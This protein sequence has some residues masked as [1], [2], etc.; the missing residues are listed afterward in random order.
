MGTIEHAFEQVTLKLEEIKSF[1]IHFRNNFRLIAVKFDGYEYNEHLDGVVSEPSNILSMPT[2]RHSKNRIEQHDYRI[3]TS[4]LQYLEENYGTYHYGIVFMPFN[5][6]FAT[7]ND[8]Q[9][10]LES[11]GIMEEFRQVFK[12]SKTKPEDELGPQVLT[13]GHLS[14]GFFVCF[15]PVIASF[16]AFIGELAWSKLLLFR[17]I[18]HETFMKPLKLIATYKFDNPQ[19]E[20]SDSSPTENDEDDTVQEIMVDVFSDHQNGCLV[21]SDTEEKKTPEITENLIALKT[22]TEK[23]TLKL[24]HSDGD[25]DSVDEL[26]K[27]LTLN[28]SAPRENRH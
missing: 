28:V 22:N 23:S 25:T 24:D 12:Y 10:K 2:Y 26:I 16:V 4:S 14:V 27:S 1:F 21:N 3:G 5:P 11:N 7:F 6:Y 13:M 8:I 15:I 19:K 18:C 17:K 9:M 20:T